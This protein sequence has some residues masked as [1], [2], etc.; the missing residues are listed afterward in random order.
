MSQTTK[1][2]CS[3]TCSPFSC[4]KNVPCRVIH[5]MG[6]CPC[7]R[8]RVVPFGSCLIV[9]SCF[10]KIKCGRQCLIEHTSFFGLFNVYQPWL[11]FGNTI[12]SFHL[13]SGRRGGSHEKL[14]GEHKCTVEKWRVCG[15]RIHKLQGVFPDVPCKHNLHLSFRFCFS[16]GL[17]N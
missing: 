8:V 7:Y 2:G 15:E 6:R 3:L 17:T 1:K 10:Q 16:G 12:I 5:S 9:L 13:F 4:R 14:N 11:M